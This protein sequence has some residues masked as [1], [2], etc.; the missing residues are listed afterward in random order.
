M[1]RPDRTVPPLAV[2]RLAADEAPFPVMV[3]PTCMFLRL[4]PA[5]AAEEISRAKTR[6]KLHIGWLRPRRCTVMGRPSRPRAAT[7][8]LNTGNNKR[9]AS[10]GCSRCWAE[11][12]VNR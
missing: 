9:E 5:K 7:A 12:S 10:R 4:S 8:R 3:I 1:R 11:N 6:T 2:L